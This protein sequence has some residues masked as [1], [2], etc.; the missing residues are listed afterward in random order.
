MKNDNAKRFPKY[1]YNVNGNMEVALKKCQLASE[2]RWTEMR[3]DI[4][5]VKDDQKMMAARLDKQAA[6]VEDIQELSSSVALLANNMDGMLKEQ[7]RQSEKLQVLEQKPAKKWENMSD[8][9][10]WFLV[11]AVLGYVLS[12][13]GIA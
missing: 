2:Q 8:K 3:L 10:L 7:Q 12:Q 11:A 1:G 4:Q 9:V 13:I 6:L 5:K